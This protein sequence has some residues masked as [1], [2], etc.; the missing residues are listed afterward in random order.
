MQLNTRIYVIII[1]IMKALIY[2]RNAHREWGRTQQ[3][4]LGQIQPTEIKSEENRVSYFDNSL[5]R[6]QKDAVSFCLDAREIALIHGP[7]GTLFLTM[8]LITYMTH[9]YLCTHNYIPKYI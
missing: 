2:L 3:V 6:Y 4:L 5:D 9:F 8:T 7:P 1:R